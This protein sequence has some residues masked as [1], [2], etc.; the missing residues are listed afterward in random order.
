MTGPGASGSGAGQRAGARAARNTIVRAAGEITGKLAS[1]VLF[2]ALGRATGETGVAA[3][4]LAFALGQLMTMP[5]EL[6]LDRYLLRQLAQ[7]R[8]ATDELYGVLAIKLGLFAPVTATGFLLVSA[9]G[10]DTTTQ[11]AL[12]VVLP[13]VFLDSLARTIYSAGLAF[14]RG[15]L[16]AFCLALR[17]IVA[18]ALGLAALAAGFGVVTVAALY[19]VAATLALALALALFARRV[20]FPRF[21]LPEAPW[22]LVV[23]SFPFAA[24]DALSVLFARVDAVI[25]SLLATQA[26]VG[27]YGAAYRLLEGTFFISWSINS[28]FAAM[29]TYLGRDTVPS[30]GSVFQRSLKLALAVLIPCAVALAVL[31]EPVSIAFFGAELEGAAGPL[32]LLAPVIP[33]VG[34]MYVTSSLIV[35]RGNPRRMVAI[36]AGMV[37]VN[38]TA[39]LLLIPAYDEEGAAAAMLVT[40]LIAVPV[41]LAIA[42]RAVGGL[43]WGLLLGGP[44]GAGLAM[45]AVLLPL[46][47]NP[48]AGL[49]AGIAVY[50]GAILALE[51]AIDPVDVRFIRR[52]LSQRLR[53]T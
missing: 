45:A 5:V 8:S 1:L 15:E 21:R 42:A 30:V 13:G 41:A 18:A 51:H 31:A 24:Q 17:G 3:Y 50:A 6:G 48:L 53:A 10:Y 33:L 12:Y 46:A 16:P 27:R 39:N 44:L 52:M 38:V 11:H 40:E 28:A 19:T 4:V 49:L 25:L 36:T 23:P 34:V 29:Y 35:S 2:A 47:G 7:D 32:R 37:V 22:R 26:A 14:E 20:G 43:R 9:A